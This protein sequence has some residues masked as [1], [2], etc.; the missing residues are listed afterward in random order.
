MG[1][2]VNPSTDEKS[3]WSHIRTWGWSRWRSSSCRRFYR[4]FYQADHL[5][6]ARENMKSWA[7]VRKYVA[8]SNLFTACSSTEQPALE[9]LRQMFGSGGV[10]AA[11]A[12]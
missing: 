12:K 2:V 5:G 8:A 6:A 1:R 11:A 7:D 9:K 3:F 4:E 10:D